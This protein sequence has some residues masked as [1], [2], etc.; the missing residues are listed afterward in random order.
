MRLQQ[1]TD[2][3][4]LY[5]LPIA[6]DIEG[7]KEFFQWLNNQLKIKAHAASSS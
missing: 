2:L 4:E 1:V 5:Y 7:E 3:K 6:F